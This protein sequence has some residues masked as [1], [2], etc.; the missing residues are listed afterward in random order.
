M[1]IYIVYRYTN[2]DRL[3]VSRSGTGQVQ[4][5]FSWPGEDPPAGGCPP[6]DKKTT[7]GSDEATSWKKILILTHF[8]FKSISVFLA[9][10]RS[11]AVVITY[12]CIA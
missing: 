4:S 6:T 5:H 11:A 9:L 1:P 12:S 7:G 10:L 3:G 8:L 2:F